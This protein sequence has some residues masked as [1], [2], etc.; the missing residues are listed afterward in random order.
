MPLFEVVKWPITLAF[1][2]FVIMLCLSIALDSSDAVCRGDLEDLT[3]GVN[4]NVY[5]L[6]FLLPIILYCLI[7]I[8][9]SIPS[10]RSI[11][12]ELGAPS[13]RSLVDKARAYFFLLMFMLIPSL[14]FLLVFMISDDF[15][16]V[17]FCIMQTAIHTGGALACTS[18]IAFPIHNKHRQLNYYFISHF[19][20]TSTFSS[21]NNAN[22]TSRSS[23]SVG[24]GGLVTEPLKQ[25][26]FN[27][28]DIDDAG[29]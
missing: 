7:S 21:F 12:D 2:F 8:V 13:L 1:V 5:G 6:C 28:S 10:L 24:G 4:S 9:L 18:I 25:S 17:L 23:V 27:S 3:S 19:F 11:R 22:F 20:D 15:N 14:V 29:E 26:A 16:N